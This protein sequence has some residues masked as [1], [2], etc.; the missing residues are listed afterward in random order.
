MAVIIDE[1]KKSKSYNNPMENGI[2]GEKYVNGYNPFTM[3]RFK[4]ICLHNTK[5]PTYI[6]F[7]QL[8]KKGDRKAPNIYPEINKKQCLNRN[9]LTFH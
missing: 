6:Q 7:R 8:T 1:H 2:K 4:Y 9:T 5:Q 3:D